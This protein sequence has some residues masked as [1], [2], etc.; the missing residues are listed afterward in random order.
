MEDHHAPGDH[1]GQVISSARVAEHAIKHLC[2]TTLSRPSMTPAEVDI[3]LAHLAAAAAAL[4]QA[5]RQ[6]GDILEQTKDDHVLEMDTLTDTLD[7]GLAIDAARLHLDGAAVAALG[8]YRRLDA[9]HN[10]TAHIAVTDLLANHS[11]GDAP[12][13]TSPVSRPEDRKPP[14][15]GLDRAGPGLR[16]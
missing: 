14:P 11:E 2:R 5:A 9:A 15:M 8:L 16:R 7:P 3:V 12:G 1:A 13:I 6:L 10:E 4:P